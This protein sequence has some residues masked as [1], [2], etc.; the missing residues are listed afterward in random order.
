MLAFNRFLA[1]AGLGLVAACGSGGE[2]GGTSPGPSTGG[3]STAGTTAN[4]MGGSNTAGSVAVAGGGAG[5]SGTAGSAPIAGTT[6]GGTGMAGSG[7][8]SGGGA[9]GSGG[10][11]GGGGGDDVA[12]PLKIDA[13]MD[14]HTHTVDQRAAGVDTRLPTIPGKLIVNVEVDD[15]G[16][17]DYGLKHGYHVLGEKIFH[18][19]VAQ[20]KNGY[21]TKGRDFNGNCRLETLDGMDHGASSGTTPATSI[22]GKVKA[23]LTT[24][25]TMYPE[26]GWPYF[27]NA[28]G[29]VRWSD[30]GFTGYSHGGTSAIRWA[31]K[32]KV[33]R[34]VARS[35]PRDNIC[36]QYADGQ[37][38]DTVV[39]S[40]LDEQSATP[41]DSLFGIDGT[42]DGEYKDIIF[43]ME[44][45]KFIGMP[46]DIGKTAAPYG[47]SH[48]L[49]ATDADNFGHDDF[50][51]KKWWPALDVMWGTPADNIAYANSH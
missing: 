16:L 25:A 4:P 20:D 26:E 24:L 10:S 39:S 22:M 34:A 18:C 23:H 48:R 7:G 42:Q 30:V 21:M 14:L 3:S 51:E 35:A 28:A 2:G 15:G 49:I 5:G 8:G 31:K 27:L 43:A 17:Y 33:W 38:P 41:A 37:C 40:W 19:E 6:T 32:L 45:M 9:G 47:G 11:G 29:D 36:G 1:L 46:T 12:H 13:T 50:V 44:R